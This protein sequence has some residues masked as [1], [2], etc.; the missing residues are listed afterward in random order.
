MLVQSWWRGRD[1]FLSPSHYDQNYLKYLFSL[2]NS[3]CVCVCVCV[4]Y[5]GK[6][7]GS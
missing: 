7:S 4:W 1:S 2:T 5:L 3:V 6:A